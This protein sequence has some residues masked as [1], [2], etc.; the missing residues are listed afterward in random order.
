[1][2]DSDVPCSMITPLC[3]RG[4]LY[5][6]MVFGTLNGTM[7]RVF[8][9]TG[10]YSGLLIDFPGVGWTCAFLCKTAPGA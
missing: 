9:G 6:A 2:P 3:Q 5:F 1:M 10:R 8:F 4:Y 7:E